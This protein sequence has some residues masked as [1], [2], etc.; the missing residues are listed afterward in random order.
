MKLSPATRAFLLCFACYAV[1]AVAQNAT[2]QQIPQFSLD[3]ERLLETEKLTIAG[4]DIPDRDL[5]LH[6]YA[7]N[8]FQPFWFGTRNIRDLVSLIDEA[9]DHGLISADYNI[10]S[11]RLILEHREKNPSTMITA[12]QDVLLTESLLLYTY[13]RRQ[14]KIKPSTLDPD[15]N[16]KRFTF[17]NDPPSEALRRLRG[18][19]SLQEFMDTVAP[20]GPFY[21]GLQVWLRRYRQI[22]SEGGWPRIPIGPT[23]RL[24][25]ASPRV[26]VVRQRLAVSGDLPQSADLSS[27]V[28]DAQLEE[29][30]TVF[31]TRH[32][33][34]NDG[35]VGQR[36]IVAMN[37]PVEDR[38][39]QIRTSLERVRWV[40]QEAVQTFVVVNIAGF[41]TFLFQ[42]GEMKWS[43]RAMVGR[44]YR[45]TPV[46][47]GD[48]QYMEFNPTWTIPPT[49]LRNDTLPAIKSDANYLASKGIRVLD[50]NGNEVDPLLPDW[51]QYSKSVPY[52]LVQDPG[53]ENALGVVKFIFP[54]KHS[55]FL[56]DTPHRE[57]FVKSERAFSSGCIRIQDPLELAERLLANTSYQASDVEAIVNSG[58]TQR[59]YLSKPVPVIITYLTASLDSD[60]NILFYRDIY[61]KDQ[62]LLDALNG[63]VNREFPETQN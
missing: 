19:G 41:R 3:T 14:G 53:P 24:G 50:R 58:Q 7:Y 21:K 30:V 15:I 40:N 48:M 29:A 61:S 32:A 44:D 47:R 27:T 45:Q 4:V 63:P 55:V 9:P 46:F 6:V 60:D 37:V 36:T 2:P 13:H 5:L 38:I 59:I 54:N 34:Q 52:T 28:F 12:E 26:A 33:L 35:I 31:Q 16:Y 23:M 49:I 39:N 62:Q 1:S 25:D 8:A 10:G 20:P 42:D 11:L 18:G 56:H 22:A 17:H 43:A 51:S 57:L